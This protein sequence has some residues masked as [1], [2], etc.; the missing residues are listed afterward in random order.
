MR[1]SKPLLPVGTV[2]TDRCR[3]HTEV[4]GAVGKDGKTIFDCP[5]CH[6]KWGFNIVRGSGARLSANQL[7][8]VLKKKGLTLAK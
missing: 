4:K 6:S 2:L 3:C 7:N 1:F 5:T 8:G